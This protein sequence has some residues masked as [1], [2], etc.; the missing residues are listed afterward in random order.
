MQHGDVPTIRKCGQYLPLARRRVCAKDSQYL[1]TVAGK[2]HMVELFGCTA[3]RCHGDA[4]RE[5][6]HSL[7]RR[8]ESDPVSKAMRQS[9]HV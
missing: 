1:I 7:N 5:S 3:P 6:L 2:D 4:I 8:S 9:P